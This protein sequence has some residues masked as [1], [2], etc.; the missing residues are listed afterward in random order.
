MLL[1]PHYSGAISCQI[2]SQLQ[3]QRWNA[4]FSKAAELDHGI[5]LKAIEVMQRSESKIDTMAQQQQQ[6][7]GHLASIGSVPTP[8]PR[9]QRAQTSMHSSDMESTLR[10]LQLRLRM[11]PEGS[12]LHTSL[13]TTLRDLQRTSGNHPLPLADLCGEAKKIGTAPVHYSATAEI[14]QGI[15]LGDSTRVVALKCLRAAMPLSQNAIKR[16]HRQVEI[17]RSVQH[18]NIIQLYGV[19]YV[20]GPNMYV[21]SPTLARPDVELDRYLVFPWMQHG[22]IT[23][24]LIKN[25]HADR[26]KLVRAAPEPKCT[27][28]D[29]SQMLGVAY[30]LAHI[31]GQDPPMVHSALQPVRSI[32]LRHAGSCAHAHAEQHPH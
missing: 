12:Q 21:P 19:S 4:Q 11:E 24:Y 31:H 3:L 15:W 18:R 29:N 23:S 9:M 30:G 1:P 13:E 17:V 25:P 27:S 5:L 28:A 10:L 26:M 7:Y 14:W 2:S 6:Q 22:D 32:S 16:F 20:D 8:P